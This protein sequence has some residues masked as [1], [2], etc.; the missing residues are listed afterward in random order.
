MVVVDG[1]SQ[2]GTT[3]TALR[4][5]CTVLTSAPG[6]GGQL[7]LGAARAT[8]DVV[9]LLHADTWVPANAGRAALDCLQRPQVVAGGFWKTFRDCPW[10]MR[11]SRLRCGIRL[12]LGG[13]IM[14]D[15]AMFIRRD[16]L[17]AVGGVPDV[18]LMEEFELCR[19]LRRVGRLALANATVATSARRFQQRGILRTYLRMW[20][21]TLRYWLGTPPE[22]L[23]RIYERR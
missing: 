21:V 4:F 12:W 16:V 20:H 7:R 14:G 2:D 17:E 10:I 18:P 13:R 6:R 11:G 9:L 19:R 5:G 8:G 23:R 1:G 15:Q 3:E 22:K